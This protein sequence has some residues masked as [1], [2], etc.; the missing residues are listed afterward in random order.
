MM[1][2]YNPDAE[3]RIT[4]DA[5]PSGLGG[6]LA[7]RQADGS[8]KPI[9]YG[10]RSLTEVESRYSQAEREA[11]AVVW[12]CQYFHFYIFDHYVTIFTD[13]KPLE[14]LLSAKSSPPPRIQ[15]WILRLQ[16]YNYS[17]KYIAGSKNAAD[18]LSRNAQISTIH[19]THVEENYIHMIVN[20][21]IPKTY[22]KSDIS[23]ATNKDDI[24]SE[25]KGQVRA[26][27]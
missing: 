12:A 20:D 21:A 9:Y 18:C 25:V 15:R 27:H 19:P 4:V 1:A 16:A 13:H 3:T 11:L 23:N 7:Q 14:S 17:I 26:K 22:S 2:F 5:S 10:S 8:F 6:I 24:L